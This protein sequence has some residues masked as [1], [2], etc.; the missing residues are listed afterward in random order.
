MKTSEKQLETL[1]PPGI[2]SSVHIPARLIRQLFFHAHTKIFLRPAL[3]SNFEAF[4]D[5]RAGSLDL[6]E[7]AELLKP[8][9]SCLAQVSL[10]H[11]AAYYLWAFAVFANSLSAVHRR[12]IK[13][14]RAMVAHCLC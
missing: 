8:L 12:K 2:H 11:V 10:V 4:D 6:V 14:S 3:F 13:T 1:T 5:V 7:A 9:V